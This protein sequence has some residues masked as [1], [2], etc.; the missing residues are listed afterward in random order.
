MINA[1]LKALRLYMVGN[2]LDAIIIPSSDPHQSEY[3]AEYWATREW[4]SGFTGSAGIVIITKD[5]AG[6]WTDSRYFLQAEEQLKDVEI[7]LHKVIKRSI[8]SHLYW[9]RDSLDENAT[10]GID[11]Y[12]FSKAAHQQIEK[13]L[14]VKNINIRL[15]NDYIS[16]V[17]KDRPEIPNNQVFSHDIMYAGQKTSEK[18]ATIRKKLSDTNANYQLIATLDDIAWTLNLRG[19]DVRLNPVFISYLIIGIDSSTLFIDKEKLDVNI[20]GK[21]NDNDINVQPYDAILNYLSE[22]KKTDTIIV[23]KTLINVALYDSMQNAQIIHQP[24]VTKKLKAQKNEIEISNYRQC[25]VRDGLALTQAFMWLEDTLKERSVSEYEFAKKIAYSRSQQ[26]HYHDES[27]DAIV[28]YKGN[29]AIIHY[30]PDK[31]KSANIKPEG[32]L[33]VDSGGQYQDGTT[34]ITRTIG[35][36]PIDSNIKKAYTSVLKGMIGLSEA[37]FPEGTT[38]AQLDILAR[39]HLWKR[40]KNFLHGTGHGVGFFLN[41]HEGPQGFVAGTTSHAQTAF[42]PGMVTSN[43]PGYYLDGEYGIR[44]ENLIVCVPSEHE[45]YLEFETITYFPIDTRII[46]YSMMTKHEVIWINDYHRLVYDK[47]SPHLDGKAKQWM[48]DKCRPI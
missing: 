31:E 28:G 45:E 39:Q 29:G 9:L 36:G 12:L 34:D 35:L 47:L 37:R 27:F 15:I 44:I 26:E 43:E 5:N 3:V 21:L 11:G 25:M 23:D 13:I 4:I 24:L 48:E 38:G 33:L 32:M 10:V 17:R 22:L 14:E 8:P 46:E 6:L 1:R 16:E 30:R 2:Q 42:L 18:I 7:D 40:G 20:K 19:S 41:V